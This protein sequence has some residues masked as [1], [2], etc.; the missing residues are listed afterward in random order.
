MSAVFRLGPHE[1]TALRALLDQALALP[2]AER[3][4][5]FDALPDDAAHAALKPH[6]RELLAHAEGRLIDTLPGVE[7]TSFAP[8][9]AGLQAGQALGPWRLLRPL[10]EGGMGSVW[11]AERTDLLQGRQVALKLPHGAWRRA[12]LAERL[13]R[14]REILA[15]LE[16]PHIARLYDA[17]VAEDGQPWL[18]LEFVDG[19]RIDAWA[20]RQALDVPA[21]VGLFLQVAQAVAHAHA[22]LVVHRDLKPANML[23]TAAGEVKLLDFGIAKLL[24]EGVAAETELT[25]EA[26]RVMTPDYASPEQVLGRPLTTASDVYALGV[27]LF[28][29]LAGRRPYTLARP[30]PAA[31]EQAIAD[32]HLPRPSSVAPP[33]RRAALRGDLDTIVLKA[34]KREPAERY[35]TVAALAEDLQRHLDHRP[36]LARPDGARYRARMFLRRHRAATAAGAAV[37]SALMAGTALALWQA[38]EAQAQRDAALAQRDRADREAT[39]ARLAQRIAEGQTSMSDFLLT[40]ASQDVPHERAVAQLERAVEMVRK[41]YRHDP[42]VRGDLLGDA[43]NRMRWIGEDGRARALFAEAEVLLRDA[44]MHDGLARVLCMRAREHA[45][46]GRLDEGRKALAEGR[47]ALARLGNPTHPHHAGCLLE[48]SVLERLA[49]DLT[50]SLALAEQALALERAAGRAETELTATLTRAVA[51]ARY[52]LGQFAGAVAAGR[53]SMDIQARIGR[54]LG[55]NLWQAWNLLAMARRDGGQTAR[56]LQEFGGEGRFDP[57]GA[58]L[59]AIQRMQYALGLLAQGRTDE[60]LRLLLAARDALAGQGSLSERRNVAVHLA[61]AQLAADRV[62]DAGATLQRVARDFEPLVAERRIASRRYLIT[63]AQWAL[64]SGAPD[65][66]AALLDQAEAVLQAARQPGDMA[67]RDLHRARAQLALA[68]GRPAEAAERASQA[69]ALSQRTAIDPQAS[70]PIAEDLLLRAQ[71]RH[72]MG[73]IAAAA[74]DARQAQQQ[75]QGAGGPQHPRV[76]EAGALSDPKL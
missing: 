26:G 31:L 32:G 61:Q 3:T 69:L 54:D 48:E 68:Q 5:W 51:R 37:L 11:L 73:D 12:G 60:S 65:L 56:A 29:L 35:A 36:V 42:A 46:A 53:E 62:A 38:R 76:G 70:L 67:W 40:D 16:H 63:R 17:G 8:A 57:A 18:A 21:R 4:R 28:E 24:Q 13:A 7:T 41:Q 1:W 9:P 20:E 14:E 23:V 25:R 30:T 19:E 44:G 50:R 52:D 10:G 22:R 43:A 34:L 72:A 59:P 74:A 6:L 15:T 55:D 71:A 27:V 66:A 39:A 33:G 47:A 45:R 75:A 58:S 49:G 2:A 64:R